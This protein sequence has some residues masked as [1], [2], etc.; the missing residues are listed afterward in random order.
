MEADRLAQEEAERRRTQQSPTL[1]AHKEQAS[2]IVV[3]RNST[4]TNGN[5]DRRCYARRTNSYRQSHRA[6]YHRFHGSVPIDALR[7]APHAGQIMD[8]VI[9]HLVAL[10]GADVQVTLEIQAKFP[11]NCPITLY[12]RLQR[13][14]VPCTLTTRQASKRSNADLAFSLCSVY[15]L[16]SVFAFAP[17]VFLLDPSCLFLLSLLVSCSF[18]SASLSAFSFSSGA[19][20]PHIDSHSSL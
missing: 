7:V 19:I 11:D 3:E 10:N 12:A 4:L 8:E 15:H 20:F 13:T 14:A 16:L 18:F 17:T 1:Y 5:A 2:P 9:K 6:R